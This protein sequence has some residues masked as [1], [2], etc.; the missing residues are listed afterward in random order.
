MSYNRKGQPNGC[1]F[2]L[3]VFL[4]GLGA[5][6][7]ADDNNEDCHEEFSGDQAYDA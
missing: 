5:E 3:P 2:L 7:E 4:R 6:V 1:P